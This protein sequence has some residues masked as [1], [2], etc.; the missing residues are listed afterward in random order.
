MDQDTEKKLRL[1]RFWLFG[2]FILVFTVI[3]L[4]VGLWIGTA[5]LGVW[6]YWVSMV[7]AALVFAGFYLVYK[8]QVS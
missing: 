5:I 7:G 4:Y 3:T 6:Q 8:R 1:M 2:S